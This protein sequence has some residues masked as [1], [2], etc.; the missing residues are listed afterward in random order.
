MF[1]ERLDEELNKVNQFYKTKETEFLERGEILN[2]QLQILLDLK[3]ILNDRRWKNS[4]SKPKYPSIPSSW[5]STPRNSDYSSGK[6]SIN[7]LLLV[8]VLSCNYILFDNLP[9]ITN[10]EGDPT[11]LIL[12]LVYYMIPHDMIAP[13][14]HG[15][16]HL[17]EMGNMDHLTL[18]IKTR[19]DF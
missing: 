6:L 1:F 14:T 5:S 17:P 11:K 16:K 10:L 18:S 3:Q 4:L 12:I 7:G 2:K 8:H 13:A 9:N 19:K 15:T